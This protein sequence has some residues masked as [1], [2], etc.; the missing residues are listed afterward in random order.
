MS[1]ELISHLSPVWPHYTPI[2]ASHAAGSYVYDNDGVEYLDF[3]CGIGVTNTGHCHPEVVEAIR[4]QAG[5]LL[6]GQINIIV[7][8]PILDLIAELRNVVPSNLDGFFFSNSGAEAVEG[9][10]KLARQATGRPN[11][12]VF[13]YGLKDLLFPGQATKQ[14]ERREGNM[15]EEI[16]LVCNT[17]FP[18]EMANQQQLVVMNPDKTVFLDILGYKF[19]KPAIDINVTIPVYSV[20]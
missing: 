12:I 1:E 11:V 14:I 19:R 17:Q 15:E 18:Q 4:E 2:V 5:L 10:I 16:Q 8:Q 3:T 7:H 6:H 9:A 20:E 13:Q